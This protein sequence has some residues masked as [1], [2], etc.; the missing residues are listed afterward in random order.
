MLGPA[1]FVDMWKARRIRSDST[2]SAEDFFYLKNLTM[3]IAD[4]DFHQGEG[5]EKL[6]FKIT[7]TGRAPGMRREG[8]LRKN[9]LRF[10]PKNH[11]ILSFSNIDNL[12][13]IYPTVFTRLCTKK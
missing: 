10:L 9:F 13:Q 7:A 6:L 1:A 8:K 4:P 12:K 11:C 5:G 3:H 2:L